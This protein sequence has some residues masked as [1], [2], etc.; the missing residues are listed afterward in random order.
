MKKVIVFIAFLLLAILPKLIHPNEFFKSLFSS[1]SGTP[2]VLKGCN[3]FIIGVSWGASITDFFLTSL[4]N[5]RNTT[6]P[7]K[8]FSTIM[9]GLQH[10]NKII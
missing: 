4:K 9:Q 7:Q 3:P 10:I 6:L 5:K 1:I 2:T 8:S